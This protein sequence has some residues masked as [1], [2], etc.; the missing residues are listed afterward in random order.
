MVR[1]ER[2]MIENGEIGDISVVKVE[3]EKEWIKE[4]V[5]EKGEKGDVWRKDKVK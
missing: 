3:Y 4:E 2:E 1:K 5:E